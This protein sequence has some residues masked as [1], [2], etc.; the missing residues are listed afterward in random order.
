M[1]KSPLLRTEPIHILQQFA[2]LN[3][4]TPY[5]KRGVDN[6]ALDLQV[7]R[8]YTSFKNISESWE[9]HKELLEA[10][11]SAALELRDGA[12]LAI[13]ETLV[14]LQA[15]AVMWI[16]SLLCCVAEGIFQCCILTIKFVS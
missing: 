14:L 6:D 4:R 8:L 9:L 2:L 1:P 3:L 15:L 12:V 11:Y 16:V 10:I 5:L 13:D 7:L